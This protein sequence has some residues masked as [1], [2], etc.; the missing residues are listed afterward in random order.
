MSRIIHQRCIATNNDGGRCKRVTL[1][2]NKCWSHLL[3][4]EHLRIKPSTIPGAGLGLFEEA[5]VKKGAFISAYTGKYRD[6]DSD[7][8]YPYGLRVGPGHVLIDGRKSNTAPARYINDARKASKNNARF[9]VYTG[10]KPHTA[11]VVAT[12]GIPKDREV[13]LPYGRDYWKSDM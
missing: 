5:P 2:S 4:D 10:K 12:K 3:R 13:F 1:R 6:D 11:K 7:K 9:S 8:F